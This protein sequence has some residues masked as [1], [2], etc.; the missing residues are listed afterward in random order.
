MTKQ[1]LIAAIAE[2][3]GQSKNAIDAVVTAFTEVVTE[4]VAA[5]EDVA[6]IG[7]G[8]FASKQREARDGFNPNSGEKIKIAAKT[9]PVFKAGK[10]FRE[11]VNA[12][13]RKTRKTAKK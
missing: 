2:K 4:K 1:E 5:G 13:K 7:F 3:T 10:V 9:V 12:P 11:A 6:L 8:T